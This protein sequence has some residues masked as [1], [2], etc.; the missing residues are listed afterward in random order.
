[1]LDVLQVEALCGF[2][3][4]TYGPMATPAVRLAAAHRL[5]AAAVREC[6]RGV[7][8]NDP[9]FAFLRARASVIHSA[10][11]GARRILAGPDAPDAAGQPKLPLITMD[12]P[13]GAVNL[14]GCRRFPGSC[15]VH[16]TRYKGAAANDDTPA[17][18][19]GNYVRTLYSLRG[20]PVYQ[21]H[22]G[23]GGAGCYYIWA[24][25]CGYTT[26]VLI[27]SMP[28]QNIDV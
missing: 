28:H 15:T 16:L 14:R 26:S 23:D 19:A 10:L 7:T 13:T 3:A 21:Q 18:W 12:E 25:I 27:H 22:Q 4:G 6:S 8:A 5:R 2:H 24:A 9:W 11:T 1:M 17:A 20:C